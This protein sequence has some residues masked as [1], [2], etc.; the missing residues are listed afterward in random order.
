M[1]RDIAAPEKRELFEYIVGRFQAAVRIESAQMR[2]P[3]VKSSVLARFQ[4]YGPA[5]S[6]LSRREPASA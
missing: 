2:S 1:N 5:R 6:P 4:R 3:E